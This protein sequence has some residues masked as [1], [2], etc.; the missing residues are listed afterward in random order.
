MLDVGERLNTYEPLWENWYKDGYIGGGNFGKV[1]RLKQN[2][3]GKI[4]YSAVKVISVM[5]ENDLNSYGED[6]Q[7]IIKSKKEKIS[8]EIVNM[9][10]LKG[11]SNLVQCLA[12][13]IKDIYDNYNN[14]VGFDVLIQME[15]YTSLTR[16]LSVSKELSIYE[17]ENLALD[18]ATGL[19]SMHDI[20]MLHRDIKVE[21][22]FIDQNNRF[23]LGDFGIS[24]QDFVNSYSTLAG[25]QSFIAPEVFRVQS[26][27]VHYSKTADI[28]SYGITLY[29]LLND[30]MLPLVKPGFRQNDIDRA[31]MDRLNGASFPPPVNGSVR[32]KNIVMKCCAYQPQD[33]FQDV[34][35][36]LAALEGQNFVFEGQNN[37][38]NGN[39]YNNRAV[40][41]PY[42]TMYADS[43]T[44]NRVDYRPVW[45]NNPADQNMGPIHSEPVTNYN[46]YSGNMSGGYD[47]SSA[48]AKK[49]S[50]K[51]LIIVLLLLMVA[52]LSVVLIMF[53]SKNSSSGNSSAPAEISAENTEKKISDNTEKTTTSASESIIMTS[54]QTTTKAATTMTTTTTTR[55]ETTTTT[56]KT[57]RKTEA[58]PPDAKK[59][60]Y[61]VFD[62][63]LVVRADEVENLPLRSLPA[64]DGSEILK[65]IPDGTTVHV[66]GFKDVGSEVWFRVDYDN[67][68]GWCRGGMLQP[69]N[70]G[71]LSGSEYNV[72]GLEKWKSKFRLQTPSSTSN[73]GTADFRGTLYFIPDLSSGV[74]KRFKSPISVEV[75][76]KMG[77]WYYVEFYDG[78]YYTGWVHQLFLKF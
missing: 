22:I 55:E 24:K 17:I 10:K 27:K 77:D 50:N 51:A 21:N 19:K 70:L 74:Q 49:S 39:P 31:I 73:Y 13:S 57:T 56:R 30:N 69:N 4:S 25:T 68:K 43:V 3:Y 33:R 41:D 26:T 62:T 46:S 38:Y 63:V 28:Y 34:K 18:I 61:K 2:L 23:Y 32:L 72:A 52:A 71:M 47:H 16:Y 76:S 58:I 12:Y 29:Y 35:E 64:K 54:E 59:Y 6:R 5:L 48:H 7:M 1:Y 11:K 36:I 65:K 67:T 44:P 42:A 8:Q 15:Y 60:G 37:T 66:L 75:T 78:E 14:I 9:Y 20:N 45:H 53:I 40:S